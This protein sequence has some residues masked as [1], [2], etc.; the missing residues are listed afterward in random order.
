MHCPQVILT[1]LLSRKLEHSSDSP[2]TSEEDDRPQRKKSTSIYPGLRYEVVS[3]T[4]SGDKQR[5]EFT[6]SGISA[7]DVDEDDKKIRRKPL[8]R[9][10]ATVESLITEHPKAPVRLLVHPPAHTEE[11]GSVRVSDLVEDTRYATSVY[12]QLMPKKLHIDTAALLGHG[13]G[14]A[15]EERDYAFFLSQ[16][17]NTLHPGTLVVSFLPSDQPYESTEIDFERCLLPAKQMPLALIGNKLFRNSKNILDT[18]EIGPFIPVSQ[19]SGSKYHFAFAEWCINTLVIRYEGAT[20]SGEPS[21][22][23]GRKILPSI[24]FD[25][26]YGFVRMMSGSQ[27]NEEEGRGSGTKI[28]LVVPD[29]AQVKRFRK[30]VEGRAKIRD[31]EEEDDSDFSNHASRLELF[32]RKLYYTVVGHPNDRPRNVW[33]I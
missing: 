3:T 24:L 4:G 5:L 1:V 2:S 31:G 7:T 21:K 22:T 12:R 17:L 6:F 26:T 19:D 33:Q 9:S 20:G 15:T 10:I 25:L 11:E 14:I 30:T 29:E 18:L 32:K 23:E 27:G 16:L 8:I 13:F 28:V